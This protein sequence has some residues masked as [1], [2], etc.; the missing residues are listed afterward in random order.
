[1]KSFLK[2]HMVAVVVLS[3]CL[4]LVVIAALL[5]ATG[6]RPVSRPSPQTTSTAAVSITEDGFV[7]SLVKISRGN[8]VTW[9][10]VDG[11][12]HRV[13][14]DPYPAST[15]ASFDSKTNLATNSTYVHMFLA[16]G[17]FTYHDEKNPTFIGTIVV[18]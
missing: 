9:T 7:P 3:I 18:E 12:P 10:N 14:A 8:S 17:T 5:S 16:P 15:S 11:D 4:T 13:A 2:Q 1:M 6:Q